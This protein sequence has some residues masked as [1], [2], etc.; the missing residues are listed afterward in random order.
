MLLGE[1]DKR[2]AGRRTGAAPCL[3]YVAA[4]RRFAKFVTS[5]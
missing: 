3:N 2:G 1:H 5:P 4:S